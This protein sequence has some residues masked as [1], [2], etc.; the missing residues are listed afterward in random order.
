MSKTP[1][2]E[3]FLRGCNHRSCSTNEVNKCEI[4]KIFLRRRLDV[5]A[6]SDTKLKRRGEVMFGEVVGRVS[7][8]TE[9]RA[10]EG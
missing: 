10:R 3:T 2:Q 7:G 9:V 5:C 6:L 1:P 4:C 8:V